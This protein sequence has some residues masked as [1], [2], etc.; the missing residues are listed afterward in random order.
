M[1]I[2]LIQAEKTKHISTSEKK[3]FRFIE[4]IETINPIKQSQTTPI[5]TE[6]ILHFRLIYIRY[7]S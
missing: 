6:V 7:F 1:K 3:P 4:K 5:Q 2:Q